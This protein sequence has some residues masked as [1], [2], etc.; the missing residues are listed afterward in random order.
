MCHSRFNRSGHV[1]IISLRCMV[2]LTPCDVL[3]IIIII[4]VII[5][6]II[7]AVLV[8]FRVVLYFVMW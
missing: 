7:I 3:F 5:I 4:I 1:F 8:V 2:I 6:I